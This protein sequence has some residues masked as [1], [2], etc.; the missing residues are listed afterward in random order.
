[1]EGWEMSSNGAVCSIATR[2]SQIGC[3]LEAVSPIRGQ[4]RRRGPRCCRRD[5]YDCGRRRGRGHADHCHADHDH[6]DRGRCGG[7]A[8]P[9]A[10]PRPG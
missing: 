2:A 5:D 9:A 4:V 10:V 3:R 1:M 6:S 7:A 8:P